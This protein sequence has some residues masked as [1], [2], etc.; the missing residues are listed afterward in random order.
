MIEGPNYVFVEN[1]KTGSSSIRQWLLAHAEGNEMKGYARHMPLREPVE[2]K[3]TFV[4]WRQPMERLYSAYRSKL[5][6]VHK[7]VSFLDWMENHETIF[8]S[9]IQWYPQ[10]GYLMYVQDVLNF[11]EREQGPMYPFHTLMRTLG[12][13]DKVDA[14]PLE[15]HNQSKFKKLGGGKEPDWWEVYDIAQ[16]RGLLQSNGD[17]R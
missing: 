8:W 12:Y 5:G 14:H 11:Y 7:G 6:N 13:G 17:R 2:D 15:H 1:P 10:L 4:V 9:P 3:R 16:R